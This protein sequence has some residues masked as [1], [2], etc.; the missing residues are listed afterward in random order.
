MPKNR[1]HGAGAPLSVSQNFL[2]SGY[3]IR[4]LLSLARLEPE[5]MV[6]EIG[7]G[8]GHITRELLGHCR[9]VRAA[10]LD[11]VLCGRLEQAFG[12]QAGFS[13]YRG[14][15]LKMP[16]PRTG[17]YQVFSNIPFSQTTAILRKLTQAPN[18]PAGAWLILE[19]GAAKRFSRDLSLRPF[20]TVKIKT[21]I[22]RREFHPAPSVNAALLELCPKA[23][24]D[25]PMEQREAFRNFLQAAKRKGLRSLLTKRQIAA[26]LRLEKL[27]PCPADGNMLYVQW[28]CLFRCW[29]TM[30]PKKNLDKKGGSRYD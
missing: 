24:P 28:L 29:Q 12:G 14:D 22:D 10:E 5:G 1:F 3:T 19:E 6:Y 23:R 2:T 11:P 18:P 26:A 13:L 4:R 30:G 20:F 7:P 27:P 8:K 15:F 25:L 17:R 9:V 21:I 16:L